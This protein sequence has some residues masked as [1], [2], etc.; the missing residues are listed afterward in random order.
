MDK[1]IVKIKEI[2][3]ISPDA[4]F[5]SLSRSVILSSPRMETAQKTRRP[6]FLELGLSFGVMAV[7]VM[8]AIL[9]GN[10]RTPGSVVTVAGLNDIENEAIA[11]KQ[12]ID[13]TLG[14]IRSFDEASGKTAMAL[15]EVSGN[16]PAHM[17]E[18]VLT[19]EMEDLDLNVKPDTDADSLLDQAIL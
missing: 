10:V 13:I 17:N 18:T 1:T 9:I 6:F 14:D 11:A 5:S 4:A 8:I 19:T 2:R 16:S 12:D 7:A 15:R 3:S